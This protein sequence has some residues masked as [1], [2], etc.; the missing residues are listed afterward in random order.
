MDSIINSVDDQL[1]DG[2]S[3]KLGNSSSYITDRREVSFY[4]S[5]SDVYSPSSGARV[6]RINLTSDNWLVRHTLRLFFLQ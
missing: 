6:V 1:V 5:G 4:A 2:L 3:Y